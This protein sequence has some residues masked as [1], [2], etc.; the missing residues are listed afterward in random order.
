MIHPFHR[1]SIVHNDGTPSEL[2]GVNMYMYMLL[3]G[4]DVHGHNH[5][6]PRSERAFAD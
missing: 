5:S 4:V 2:H 6:T 3:R 1:V